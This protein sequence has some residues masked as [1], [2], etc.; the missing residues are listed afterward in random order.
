MYR[1]LLVPLDGSDLSAINTSEAIRLASLIG[2]GIT[3]FHAVAGETL[4]Q[5]DNEEGTELLGHAASAATSA[6]VRCKVELVAAEKPASA[7][8][9]ASRRLGCD[10]IVMASHGPSGLFAHSNT[11]EVV[12]RSPVAVLITQV[13]SNHPD[14]AA[15]RIISL[16]Q[17]E[18]RAMSQVLGA[19]Q[20]LVEHARQQPIVAGRS[21]LNLP[22]LSRMVHYLRDF[23]DHW[24]HHRE[25]LA[26]HDPLRQRSADTGVLLDRLEVEH[27]RQRE[28]ARSLASAVDHCQI[29]GRVD[30]LLLHTLQLHLQTLSR[31]ISS[32]ISMEERTLLPLARDLLTEQDWARAAQIFDG[33]ID[34]PTVPDPLVPLPRS[35]DPS[36]DPSMRRLYAEI[37][38]DMAAIDNPHP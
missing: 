2:A 6:G 12:R 15:G 29:T 4:S 30:E 8:V 18:H 36:G 1:H 27:L 16:I 14:A 24:H 3:F 11:E 37:L 34:S 33:H 25:D 7:I 5:R 35:A 19:A 23:P 31:T 22:V 17:D 9:Q 10:L 20:R 38:R 13:E 32:H 28:L 26:I 21:S